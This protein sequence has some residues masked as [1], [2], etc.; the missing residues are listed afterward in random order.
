MKL[1][2]I[3]ERWHLTSLKVNVKVLQAEFKPNDYDKKCAWDLYV[4]LLTRITTQALDSKHGDEKTALD[5]IYSLFETTREILREHG[6]ESKEFTKIS[7]I[8]LNQ[9]VRPFTAKWHKK[10]IENAFEDEEQCIKFRKE[11]AD[12]QVVLKR[13]T[14]LLAEM[15]EVEDLTDVEIE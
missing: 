2:D 13:Y 8:V 9:I 3:F 10:S 6:R 14:Q 1:R 7:I 4:E 5:S 12:L 11:L 15:A